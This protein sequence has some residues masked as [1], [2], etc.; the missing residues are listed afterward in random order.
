MVATRSESV[1][2]KVLTRFLD[3]LATAFK[4]SHLKLAN[5]LVSEGII[6]RNVLDKELTVGVDDA[7]KATFIVNCALD[8]IQRYPTKY[9]DF[10]AISSLNESCHRSLREEMTAVYG[11]S[12]C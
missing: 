4:A 11:R 1:E 7:T 3:K 6:P 12:M 5:E 9:Q 10:M 2:V 8:Q